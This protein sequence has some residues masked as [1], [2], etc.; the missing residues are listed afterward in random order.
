[1][2]QQQS[3][4]MNDQR[5]IYGVYTQSMLTMKISLP[6]NQ[7]GK[8]IKN[9]LEKN[10]QKKME[11]KCMSQGY[12][13]PGSVRV[14][15]YSSGIISSQNIEFHTVFECMICH[16]MEGMIIECVVKT[17]TKAG[18]HAEVVDADGFIPVTVFVARDHHFQ[19]RNFA[20]IKE[21]AKI[22]IRVIGVRFE[23]N[24]PYISVI[25]KFIDNFIKNVN[26]MEV[27]PRLYIGGDDEDAAF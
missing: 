18:I 20:N 6:V 8:N 1:M 13:R 14:I 17:I 19:D 3:L 4:K 9:N 2:A 21:S 7:V 22:T 23:L 15:S 12:I 11:G 5:K 16:P 27:K 10:I 24:D 26:G 25:G